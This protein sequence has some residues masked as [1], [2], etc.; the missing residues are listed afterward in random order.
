MTTHFGDERTAGETPMSGDGLATA[1]GDVAG[2]GVGA[3]DGGIGDRR[4][5]GDAELAPGLVDLAVNVRLAPLP[6]TP[7]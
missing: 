3:R 2:D 5:H 4:Y 7:A 1:Q 6:A